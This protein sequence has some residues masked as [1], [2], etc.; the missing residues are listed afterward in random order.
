MSEQRLTPERPDPID[1]AD[2]QDLRVEILRLRDL[3][4]GLGSSTE[5]SAD[6][7]AQLETQNNELADRAAQLETQ[8]NEL[9]DRAAQLETQNNELADRAAQFETQ[10]NE[11][12]NV[13]NELNEVNRAL[14]AELG[15][16]PMIRIARAVARRLKLR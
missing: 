5:V 14:H 8:N 2:P 16:S 7:A 3:V 11:L 15:R 12:D 6:R 10:N 1:S 4:L 9:A 13:V